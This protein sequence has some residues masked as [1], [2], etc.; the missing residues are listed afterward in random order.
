M[1]AGLKVLTFQYWC[2]YCF[3]LIAVIYLQTIVYQ[4]AKEDFGCLVNWVLKL[5]KV[6]QIVFLIVGRK[7]GKFCLIPGRHYDKLHVQLQANHHWCVKHLDS[8]WWRYWDTQYSLCRNC[9]IDS[10]CRMP[11]LVWSL[12][13]S[14]R[15]VSGEWHETS[16]H[17]QK[18]PWPL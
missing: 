7:Y 12:L 6:W 5:N 4:L 18:V 14:W 8:L 11:F 13:P 17:L 2:G 10:G 16:F 1:G 3:F 9:F 15:S